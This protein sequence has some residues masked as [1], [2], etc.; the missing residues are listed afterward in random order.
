MISR[1]TGNASQN[2]TK[3][4]LPPQSER[5]EANNVSESF[6]D[7]VF[8]ETTAIKNTVLEAANEKFQSVMKE[9]G[10]NGSL[11]FN[12]EKNTFRFT[13]NLSGFRSVYKAISSN[14]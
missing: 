1:H 3:T 4:P 14:K 9:K 6:E 13:Y 8:E 11:T 10:I 5:I 7:F 12:K 2:N